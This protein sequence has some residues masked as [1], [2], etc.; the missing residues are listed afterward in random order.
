MF[1]IQ[2]CFIV[3]EL[4]T[5]HIST[6]PTFLSGNTPLARTENVWVLMCPVCSLAVVGVWVLTVKE[7]E[8][9]CLLYR[10]WFL[11]LMYLFR[12]YMFSPCL[13]WLVIF[14]F[15]FKEENENVGAGRGVT[16]LCFQ[17][18]E[19]FKLSPGELPLRIRTLGVWSVVTNLKKYTS[20]QLHV[21]S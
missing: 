9:S 13:W 7:K 18:A 14:S 20:L 2:A 17:K 3:L 16:S 8:C 6:K 5:L 10:I 15:P 21:L 4:A 12:Y 19:L 1:S 11:L